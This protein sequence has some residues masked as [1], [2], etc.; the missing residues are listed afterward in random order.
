MTSGNLWNYYRDEV[1]DDADENNSGNS[2]T[3]TS[4]SFEYKT[5]IIESTSA[6]NN[7][8]DTEV[9]VPLKY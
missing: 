4:K 5:K 8:L 7:T 3:V 2:K 6:N 9:A 1:N